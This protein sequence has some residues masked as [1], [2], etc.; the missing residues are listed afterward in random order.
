MWYLYILLCRDGSF[1]T[2]IAKNLEQRL[3][4]HNRGRGSKYTRARRPV[5][6]LYSEACGLRSSAQKREAEVK[7][8]SAE[9]KRR[10]VQYG[11]GQRFPSAQKIK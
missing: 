2:G 1:Y 11:L 8:F 10:L 7:S 4:R 9:N 3:Q 6:M 5:E